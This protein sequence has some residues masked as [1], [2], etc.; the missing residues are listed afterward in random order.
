MTPIHN[1]MP[2]I[3]GRDALEL[4][5]DPAVT[6]AADVFPLLR[7]C[8]DDRLTCHPVSSLVN[9]IRNDGPALVE[10]VDC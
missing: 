1:R 8:A 3:L 4:R 2:L 10:P 6:E 7:P 5:L 9:S